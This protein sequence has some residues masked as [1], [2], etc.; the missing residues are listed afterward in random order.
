[1]ADD[2]G[3]DYSMLSKLFSEKKERQLPI[4]LLLKIERAKALLLYNEM[5]LSEIAIQL[6]YS[7]VAHLSSQFKKNHGLY[8]TQFKQLKDNT[9]KQID[10]L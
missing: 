10:G 4:I 1:L 6:N 2:L 3:Q 5:T 9:R 8:P 7:S